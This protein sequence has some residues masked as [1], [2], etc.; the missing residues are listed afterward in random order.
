MEN[1][2]MFE[3][4]EVEVLEFNGKVLFNPKMWLKF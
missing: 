1:L 2:M 4:N 3:G